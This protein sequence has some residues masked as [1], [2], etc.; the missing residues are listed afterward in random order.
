[1]T[2]KAVALMGATGTG[3]SA[4]AMEIAEKNDLCIIACDSMQVYRKLDIGT[5]KPTL[6]EQQQVRHAVLDCV[7]ISQ[8]FNAQTWANQA[9]EVIKSE[10]A[11][12]KMPLIVGGTGMYLRALREG[13]AE[14]PPEK[15]GVR[16]QF[17]ALQQEHG[18]PYLHEKL[19]QVDA[20]LAA[21]L[22]E[23]D[24]QRIIRGL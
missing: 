2:L 13:F 9:R 1:M 16:E 21:R 8:T 15:E 23:H 10:N 24:T 7:D 12:G 5:A 6:N 17:E 14:V 3:K 11:L 18:T 19:R 4:L 22:A 20:V